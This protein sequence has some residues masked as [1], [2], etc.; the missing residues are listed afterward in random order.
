MLNF[1]LP[2]DPY[3]GSNK[4]RNLAELAIIIRRALLIKSL[5]ETF[6]NAV[7]LVVTRIIP[8]A[9]P[10]LIVFA[11]IPRVLHFDP[12]F[13]VDPYMVL[14]YRHKFAPKYY[15]VLIL[16]YAIIGMFDMLIYGFTVLAV[17]YSAWFIFQ[18][19]PAHRNSGPRGPQRPDTKRKRLK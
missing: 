3:D 4:V 15:I 6:R 11:V 18:R 10:G 13:P 12:I 1:N 16:L 9:I 17:Q 7:K 14:K 19:K 8:N 2:Y 5:R